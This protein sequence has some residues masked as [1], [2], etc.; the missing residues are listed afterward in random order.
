MYSVFG[1]LQTC[2]ETMSRT[3][4]SLSLLYLKDRM[5]PASKHLEFP[6]SVLG[7]FLL[8]LVS[9]SQQGQ[10]SK[11]FYI[12]SASPKGHEGDRSSVQIYI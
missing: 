7:M 4:L 1:L 3:P 2:F 10:F 9:F 5:T 6:H 12:L 8:L 11:Q